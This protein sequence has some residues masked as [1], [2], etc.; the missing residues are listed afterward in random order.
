VSD[1]GLAKWLDTSTDLT[2]TITVFGTPGYIAPEQAE[3]PAANLTPTADVYSLGAILSGYSRVVLL[4]L[5]NMPSRSF[6]RPRIRKRQ[7]Y[8]R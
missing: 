4:F 6:V 2:R 5:A 8:V 3:G 1:F 7:S